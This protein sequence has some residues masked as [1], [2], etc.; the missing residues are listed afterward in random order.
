[1]GD[2]GHTASLFPHTR[3][4]DATALAVDN[5]VPKLDA[6]RLTFTAPLINAAR[7]IVFLAGGPGQGGNAGSG[8]GG[9]R[10]TG[11]YP[12]QSIRPAQPGSRFSWLVDADAAALLHR[13]R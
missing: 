4:L 3:A 2:D 11:E 8:P 13:S 9:P 10:A 6:D 7:Q 12:A 5:F 1:M